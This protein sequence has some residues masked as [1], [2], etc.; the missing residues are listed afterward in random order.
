MLVFILAGLI[1]CLLFNLLLRSAGW[2]TASLTI[3]VELFAG[4]L[5][6][7]LLVLFLYFLFDSWLAVHLFRGCP[8]C[9]LVLT[10]WSVGF[11]I[12]W[13]GTGIAVCR[14]LL[15]VSFLV[16]FFLLV[17][18][19]CGLRVSWLVV[20]TFI[21]ASMLS[22]YRQ[23]ESNRLALFIAFSLCLAGLFLEHLALHTGRLGCG[24]LF[25]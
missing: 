19:L 24:S 11:C 23:E 6:I 21:L 25:G 5:D 3:I 10:N 1:I 2:H 17:R 20:L 9:F 8:N 12:C 16:S 15:Q 7:L 18:R 13:I 14:I 22:F 4:G